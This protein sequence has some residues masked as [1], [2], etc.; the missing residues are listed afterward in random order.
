[1]A[2]RFIARADV[3]AGLGIEVTEH[4]MGAGTY[5]E[6]DDTG[7]TTMPGVWV[8]GVLAN[9]RLQ[10]IGAA[11]GGSMAAAA[12]N[13]D[14]IAADTAHAVSVY[15]DG[16]SSN[17]SGRGTQAGHADTSPERVAL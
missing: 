2:P 10:V 5:V 9:P 12:I 7:L 8:A 3:L 17:L 15:R 6:S 1:V 11:A 4:P 14:L 13:A 16:S